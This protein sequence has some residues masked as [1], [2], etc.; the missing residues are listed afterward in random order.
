TET[1]A[2]LTGAVR[3]RATR[4][5]RG[6]LFARAS[7]VDLSRTT[8]NFCTVHCCNGCICFFV[9]AHGDKAKTLRTTGFA[10]E[11]DLGGDYFSELSKHL[12][13]FLIGKVIRQVTY[14]YIHWF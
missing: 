10:V 4:S 3:E 8:S 11:D 14:V 13:Q 2:T 1:A 5:R 7:R 6:T 12:G 9:I